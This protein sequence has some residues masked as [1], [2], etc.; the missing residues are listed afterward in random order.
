MDQEQIDAAKQRVARRA[1][2]RQEAAAEARRTLPADY[3]RSLRI[4]F[5]QGARQARLITRMNQGR[6]LND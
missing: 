1:Q 4:Q 6:S 2:L 3:R 5:E